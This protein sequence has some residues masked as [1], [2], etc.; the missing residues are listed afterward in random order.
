MIRSIVKGVSL[1]TKTLKE[2]YAFPAVE[3][4]SGTTSAIADDCNEA[5]SIFRFE[6]WVSAKMFLS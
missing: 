3:A 1:K 5:C 4:H 6:I 2:S